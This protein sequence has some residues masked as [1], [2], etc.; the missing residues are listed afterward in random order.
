[1]APVFDVSRR[2]LVLTLEHGAVVSRVLETIE[3][4]M[5]VLKVERL[6]ELGVQTL[7]CGAISEP[8]QHELSRMGVKVI[9]FVAGEI[10]EVVESFLA[11]ALPSRALCMPGCCGRPHR[12]RGAPGR[13]G[14]G[15]RGCGRQRRP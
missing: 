14:R 12:F 8:L 2:A 15:G 3:T 5:P 13:E 4:P 7:V 11:G 6:T 10:E 9:A 1:M